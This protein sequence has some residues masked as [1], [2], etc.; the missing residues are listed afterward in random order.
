MKLLV[1][2]S[3]G[4]LGQHLVKS[5]QSRGHVLT[6]YDLLKNN[7]TSN[8]IIGDLADKDKIS[9]VVKNFDMVIHLGAIS[10]IDEC[11]NNPQD[12]IN[13]NLL[14]TINLLNACVKNNVKNFVFASS[15]YVNG[16]EGGIYRYTKQS[17]ELII[18]EYGK[19]FDIK[20]LILRY[21][22][23]YGPGSNENNG[24]YRIIKNALENSYV[25]YEGNKDTTREYIHVVDAATA[26]IEL[27]E[28]L[29]S[30]NTFVISGYQTQKVDELLSIISEMLGYKQQI[31]FEKKNLTGHYVRTPHRVSKEY[32]KKYIPKYHID[33]GEGLAELIDYVK[34]KEKV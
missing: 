16:S 28:R 9:D 20:Y 5:L 21:G 15:I 12:A 1:T 7:D 14:G 26:T 18:N 33:L 23:L 24:L 25:S 30:S 4:F 13:V 3:N 19:I 10:D 2:G 32:S 27:L 22:S 29:E 17:S 6:S 34:E 8:S 11:Q 31:R